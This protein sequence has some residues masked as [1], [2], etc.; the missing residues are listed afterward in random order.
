MDD[1]ISRFTRIPT[2][3]NRT[4][5]LKMSPKKRGGLKQSAS[6]AGKPFNE[7]VKTELLTKM[8]ANCNGGRCPRCAD[9][10]HGHILYYDEEFKRSH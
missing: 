1:T 3:F 4:K 7:D 5:Q 9:F 2:L 10:S 6:A 8:I